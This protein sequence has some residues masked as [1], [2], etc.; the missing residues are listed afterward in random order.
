LSKENKVWIATWITDID[1]E[2]ARGWDMYDYLDIPSVVFNMDNF[3]AAKKRA[4]EDWKELAE[5]IGDGEV[6]SFT[7][8]LKQERPGYKAWSVKIHTQSPH[9]IE[10]G[11]SMREATV[12]EE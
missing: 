2:D 7:W 10:A 12:H 11:M 8:R 5:M 9:P 4:E 6:K 1:V 3:D